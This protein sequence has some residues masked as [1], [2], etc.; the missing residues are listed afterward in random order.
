MFSK[1]SVHTNALMRLGLPSTPIRSAFSSKMYGF[2]VKTLLKVDQS[3]NKNMTYQYGRS[4][5]NENETITEYIA[6]VCV[7]SMYTEFN[8]CH[9][10]QFYR[11]Q[12]FQ[13]GHSKSMKALVWVD[14]NRS[15]RF[16]WQHFWK[17]IYSVERVLKNNKSQIDSDGALTFYLAFA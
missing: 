12:T 3:Q 5:T 2:A 15:M 6:G 4:K 14:T 1:Q 7:W 8:L 16:R 17:H 10:V 11:S 9:N 13:C